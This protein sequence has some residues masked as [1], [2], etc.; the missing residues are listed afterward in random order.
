MMA[1]ALALVLM[2]AAPQAQVQ[3]YF[4]SNLADAAYQQQVFGRVAKHWAMPRAK[5]APKP[6]EKAVVQVLI[7]G[8]GKVLSAAVSTQSGSA[9]WDDAALAAVKG[10]AP[11]PS[12]PKSLGAT[13]LEFHVHITRT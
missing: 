13:T 3:V 2:S 1:L 11:F 9:K 12:L 6:G 4:Q 8:S 5:D 10:A 7:D